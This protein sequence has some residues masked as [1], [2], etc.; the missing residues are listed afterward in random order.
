M[1]YY[2][3]QLHLVHGCKMLPPMDSMKRRNILLNVV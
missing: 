1:A 2:M 3:S